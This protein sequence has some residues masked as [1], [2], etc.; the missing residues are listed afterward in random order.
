[1]ET[2][3]IRV[4]FTTERPVIPDQFFTN[5][6]IATDKGANDAQLAAAQWV[7]SAVEMVT[8]TQIVRVEV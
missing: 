3:F 5:V 1:V 6:V 2:F 4:G 8:S 7:G